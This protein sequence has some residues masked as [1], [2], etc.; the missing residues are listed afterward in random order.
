MA[1]ITTNSVINF[2]LW[3]RSL[4]DFKAAVE[5]DESPIVASNIYFIA[6]DKTIYLDG[7][8]Y[9]VTGDDLTSLTTAISTNANAIQGIASIIAAPIQVHNIAEDGQDPQYAYTT[10]SAALSYLDQQIESL[11]TQ[12]GSGSV[13]SQISSAI[14]T[15][16]DSLD[17]TVKA[18]LDEND[19]ITEGHK[20][21]VKVVETDG[22]LTSVTVVENDIAS[23][24][25]LTTAQNAINTLNGDNTTTGSV[26]KSI[27]DASDLLIGT[28]GAQGTEESIRGAKAY[29]DAAAAAAQQA[30]ENAAAE[31]VNSLAG[32]NWAE[33]AKTVKNIIDE[34]SD[35]GNADFATFIDKVRGDYTY[36]NQGQQGVKG[37][38]D[39]K[40]ANAINTAATNASASATGLI[41]DLDATVSDNYTEGSGD[42]P[43]APTSGHV[44]IKIT[45]DNGKLTSVDILESDIASAATLSSV[46]STVNSN[47]QAI[48]NLQNQLKWIV[49]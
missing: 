37:Y 43:S 12:A 20:V 44:G 34:L 31:L 23:A 36:G 41:N 28:Q 47:S 39:E 6:A 42:N 24:S 22:K 9:G 21:G 5:L 7:V 45:E 27:K 19:A 8:Y 1:T 3:T 48:T 25:A 49:A 14:A 11:Q 2:V 26:A 18:N 16:K 10:I 40:V 38:I 15:L 33:N 46:S 32:D 30:A 4:S 13:A 17:A 35:S 29:A